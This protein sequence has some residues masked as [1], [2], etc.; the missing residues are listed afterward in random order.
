MLGPRA[1]DAQYASEMA[2]DAK[3]RARPHV[4]INITGRIRCRLRRQRPL[5]AKR[6]AIRRVR[7]PEYPGLVFEMVHRPERADQRRR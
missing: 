1:S 3:E 4:P 7:R 5:T 2:E 6:Q